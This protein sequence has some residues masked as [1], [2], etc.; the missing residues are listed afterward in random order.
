MVTIGVDRADLARLFDSVEEGARISSPWSVAEERAL[1]VF[2]ARGPH[3]TLQEIWPSLA[4]A[5]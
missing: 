2:V 1:V 5:N 4:G 3:R